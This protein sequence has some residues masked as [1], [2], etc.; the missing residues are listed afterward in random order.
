[1]HLSILEKIR[2]EIRLNTLSD[3]AEA[4]HRLVGLAGLSAQQRAAIS[5]R[6]IDLVRTTERY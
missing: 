6:A 1:M 4:L 5:S 3:E 2:A